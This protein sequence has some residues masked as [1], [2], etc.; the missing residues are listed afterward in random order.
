MNKSTCRKNWKS[1]Q[2]A[3]KYVKAQGTSFPSEGDNCYSAG[4][5]T[6]QTM[7]QLL[8]RPLS[9]SL[10]MPLKSVGEGGLLS[11]LTNHP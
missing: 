4:M 7:W 6:L 10:C 11:F 9:H 3:E 5:H 8:S 1:V 2:K